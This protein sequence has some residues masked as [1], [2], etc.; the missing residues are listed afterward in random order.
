MFCDYQYQPP[1]AGVRP[2]LATSATFVEPGLSMPTPHPSNPQQAVNNEQSLYP[3]PGYNNYN[4]SDYVNTYL[5]T[6]ARKQ[7]ETSFMNTPFNRSDPPV[8]S[9]LT[10]DLKHISCTSSTG[11]YV[12]TAVATPISSFPPEY[13]FLSVL[14]RA[15]LRR[16]RGLENVR[17][18][19]CANEYPESFTGQEAIV[20]YKMDM[21]I[22]NTHI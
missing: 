13:A 7:Q 4:H 20:S 11:S 5:T 6:N 12:T 9:I 17:D 10:T 14:S 2:A 19:F 16:V 8:P 1:P 18:L 3:S 15:F 21:L 22:Y